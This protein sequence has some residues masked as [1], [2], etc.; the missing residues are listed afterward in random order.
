MVGLAET[1]FRSCEACGGA[2]DIQDQRWPWMMIEVPNDHV[3]TIETRL[4]YHFGRRPMPDSSTGFLCVNND[5][6]RIEEE[7]HDRWQRKKIRAAGSMLIL[8]VSHHRVPPGGQLGN[9]VL[10]LSE[11][12]DLSQYYE[13]ENARRV[14]QY[15]LCAVIY[16]LGDN[17]DSGH[18]ICFARSPNRGQDQP[19]WVLLDDLDTDDPVADVELDAVLN[20]TT[21]LGD[22]NSERRPFMVFYERVYNVPEHG[23]LKIRE[24]EATFYGE[25]NDSDSDW[26]ADSDSY[27]DGDGTGTGE[28]QP[29]QEE[30]GSEQ[31]AEQTTTEE[32]ELETSGDEEQET[33]TAQDQNDTDYVQNEADVAANEAA[34][35][36]AA[37]AEAEAE[38]EADVDVDAE[39]E[40]QE[41]TRN[42]AK[43][44]PKTRRKREKDDDEE[45]SK[46]TKKQKKGTEKKQES[47]SELESEPEQPLKRQTRSQTKQQNAEPKKKD[48]KK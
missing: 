16:H 27:G 12:I 19:E 13:T 39:G 1:R 15:K 44:S 46:K 5:C 47:E 21:E 42:K 26:N 6:S 48:K 32:S 2:I 7:R 28:R 45:K 14:L 20:R 36:E 17:P 43:D 23:P 37:E 18:Y 40:T 10:H 3:S 35:A 30:Q 22:E 8:Y 11:Y 38:T 41:T 34:E 24:G 4:A 33:A 9:G 25:V 29:Q 31:D